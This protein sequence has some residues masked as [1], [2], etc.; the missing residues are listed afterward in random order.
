MTIPANMAIESAMNQQ[1]VSLSV[2]KQN[3]EAEQAVASILE[4]ASRNVPVSSLRGSNVNIT[5]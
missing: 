2:I 3:A 1:A 4:E 5:A